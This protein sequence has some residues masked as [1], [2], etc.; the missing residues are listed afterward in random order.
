MGC[1]NS[2]GSNLGAGFSQL[3]QA[4]GVLSHQS[5][6]KT[7]YIGVFAGCCRGNFSLCARHAVHEALGQEHV[8]ADLFPSEQ[9]RVQQIL[10]N[11]NYQRG[12]LRKA[13]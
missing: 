13:F 10:G 8:P 3:R 5:M 7:N 2:W 4:C 12:G 11:A 1:E 6:K 9:V